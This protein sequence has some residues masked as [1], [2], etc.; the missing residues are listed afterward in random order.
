MVQR[1][2]F[3]G[4]TNSM[5]ELERVKQEYA[6]YAYIISH[7]L[8]APLRHIREFSK[9]LVSKRDTQSKQDEETYI[10]FI[11]QS[12]DKLDL[13]QKALLTFS[14][15]NTTFDTKKAIDIN[16]IIQ[17][18]L[19]DY[20]QI[21][22]DKEANISIQGNAEIIG[23]HN[24]IHLMLSHIIDNA[25]SFHD[26]DTAPKINILIQNK[27]NNVVVVDDNG[28]GFDTV[29]KDNIFKLFFQIKPNENNKTG[30]GLA[31]IKKIIQLHTGSIEAISAPNEGATFLITLP[32]K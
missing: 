26:T 6:E 12:L 1:C 19:H 22:T 13:M 3:A 15:I 32:K 23:D 11:N 2:Y 5:S 24:L 31:F 8:S 18:V 16:D 9:L 21:I 30:A 7:D 29:Y 10:Q 27:D 28:I 20:S 17:D 4:K 14:R 25:L